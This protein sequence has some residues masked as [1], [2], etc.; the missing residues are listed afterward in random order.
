[1]DSDKNLINRKK[2]I[3][4]I[5]TSFNYFVD[6]EINSFLRMYNNLIYFH[7]HK[8]YNVIVLQPYSDKN[9]E[10]YKLKKNIITYYFREIK[11]FNNNL[12]PFTDFNPFYFYKVLKVIKKHKIDLIHVDF[13]YGINC[14]RFLKKIPLSY[15]AHN[16][17][18]V[19]ANQIGKFDKKIPK[20]L[21]KFFEKYVYILEKNV[22]KIVQNINALS[23]ND[24]NDFLK[25]YNT[26]K[27][28]III[29]SLGLN[30]KINS[31]LIEQK[32][33]RRRLNIDENKFVIVFHGNLYKRDNIEALKIIKEEI[34]PKTDDKLFLFLIA[35][36]MP[37]YKN[38]L[39]LRYLG[40]LDELNEFLCAADVAIIPV[41]RGSGINTKIIDYLSAY[42]PIITTKIGSRGLSLENG[43]HGY[44]VT[45]PI[46]DTIEK[47]NELRNNP[48]KL[49]EFR[50]NIKELVWDKYN[51]DRILEGIAKRY[52]TLIEYYKTISN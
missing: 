1:M 50:R 27:E 20:I 11:I 7:N 43:L 4:F 13:L 49:D 37:P 31:N 36:K 41:L 34:I 8:D 5:S 21:R 33:A 40:F 25:I 14:L 26:P 24:K 18:F 15:N 23:S 2:N 3:L 42:L 51:W 48:E 28:K 19:Y 35:G 44:I 45:D 38:Q 6:N 30:N 10:N 32:I 29:N 22:L 47:L 39:N 12:V 16:V 9:K 46:K 52:N 17:E